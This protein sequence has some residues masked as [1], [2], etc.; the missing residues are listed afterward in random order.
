[1]VLAWRTP[2]STTPRCPTW[3]S[4]SFWAPCTPL[5][6][7]T[8]TPREYYITMVAWVTNT[9]V[10]V[11]WL[12]RAQNFSILTFCDAT[13]GACVQKHRSSSDTWLTQQVLSVC[14]LIC[15]P[16]NLSISLS[17]SLTLSLS[18]SLSLS[19]TLS[20]SLS[21]HLCCQEQPPVLSADGET[22]F[23]ITPTKQGNQ[24][25]FQHVVMFVPQLF[26]EHRS[27]RQINTPVQVRALTRTGA[28]SPGAEL[29]RVRKPEPPA[30]YN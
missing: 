28:V 19:D 15:L 20:I 9:C 7:S 16:L 8:R 2:S 24:R 11:R 23:L 14:L 4:P 6:K 10:A 12:N 25:D 1:M 29:S 3:R 30:V 17:D 5:A 13:N 26:P 21:L 18:L 22:L 27:L